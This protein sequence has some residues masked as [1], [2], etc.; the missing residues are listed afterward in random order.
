MP[1]RRPIDTV[2][3]SGGHLK[4]GPPGNDSPITAMCEI[5]GFLC[6][7]KT[8]GIY[9]LKLPDQVDPH[10]TNPALP[11]SQRQVLAYGSDCE[12]VVRTLL[13][14]NALFKPEY[15]GSAFDRKQALDLAFSALRDLISMHEMA[16][17]LEAAQAEAKAHMT[18]SGTL[19]IPSVPD[20]IGRCE[21]FIQK[22]HHAYL[23]L[24]KIA[25]LFYGDLGKRQVDRLVEVVHASHG[26][27]TGLVRLL[28]RVSP[29]LHFI[30]RT[31]H[32]VEHAKEDQR[33][34]VLDFTLCADGMIIPPTIEVVDKE[35]PHHRIDV[36]VFMKGVTDRLSQ[37]FEVMIASLCGHNTQAL[38][39][40]PIV[41][42]EL[43]A[44]Q[45]SASHVR[46]SYGL[47]DGSRIVTMV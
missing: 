36:L 18:E 35:K 43:P 20:I 13:T 25:E 41:V 6:A 45:R 24:L 30:R 33:I 14:A 32:C 10:R 1:G 38:G 44:D 34:V 26:E 42:M 27:D 8:D 5:G 15:L 29:F 47:Q 3:D 7:V 16:T 39:G 9:E 40:L 23:D 21:A 46:F 11:K 28:R 17:S 2:R 12:I 37:I 22:A 31:R 19:F 4:I